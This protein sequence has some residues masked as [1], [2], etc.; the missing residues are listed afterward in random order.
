[1][2]PPKGVYIMIDRHLVV[3]IVIVEN[4]KYFNAEKGEPISNGKSHLSV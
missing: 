1:M 4:H 3:F 2:V